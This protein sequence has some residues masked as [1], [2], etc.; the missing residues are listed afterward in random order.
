[1][2]N[3]SV[4]IGNENGYYPTVQSLDLKWIRFNLF[5]RVIL[6]VV[7]I[8]IMFISKAQPVI[9]SFTPTS[10]PIGTSV[11]ITGSNFNATIASNVVYFG[12][13]Q[14]TVTAASDTSLTVT[15]PAG[16]TYQPISVINTSTNLSGY[17]KQPFTV[18]FNG[19]VGQTITS[20]SF[21]TRVNYTTG[22]NP[23]SIVAI[24]DIDGDGKPDMVV[25]DRLT[26]TFS[27]LRNTSTVGITTSSFAAKV[28]FTTDSTPSSVAIG[29][30]DGDG[31]LD[32]V[33]TN[34]FKN[35]IWVYR[36]TS[37]SGSITT[38]SFATGV[39]FISDTL[40]L[41]TSVAIGDLDG[42]GKPDLAVTNSYSNTVSILKN[43]ST[44]GSITNASFAKSVDFTTGLGPISVA[45]ADIDGDGK[46]DLAV[47]N[48]NA[49]TISIFRNTTTTGTIST[50]SFAAKVDFTAG[51]GPHCVT[52]GD[53]NSD[54]KM[55]L[56]VANQGSNTI[57]VF[58]NTATSGTI[59]TSSLAAQV[60]IP[61]NGESPYYVSVGNIDGD[62]HPDI[63]VSNQIGNKMVV[64]RNNYAS[65]NI[66]ASS[67]AAGVTFATGN[68]PFSVAV[69]DLDGDGKPD[70]AVPN[71]GDNTVSVYW[72]ALSNVLPVSFLSFTGQYQNTP[73]DVLLQ[74]K[75]ANET[76]TS[77]FNIQRSVNGTLFTPLGRQDAAGNS[78]SVESYSY[79][80]NNLPT[81]GNTTLY[82]RLQEVDI[83][84][85]ITYSNI[86]P[87]DI[88]KKGTFKIYPN[89]AKS[90]INI[91]TDNTT[92]NGMVIISD[93]SGRVVLMY[94]LSSNQ[95]QQIPLGT[96]A[97]GL[98]GVSVITVDGKQTQQIVVQ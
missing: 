86:V 12:A 55:D 31:K 33:I 4:Y 41:P 43:T 38:S 68:Y 2:K 64:I 60:V 45:I 87:I 25:V 36:N 20:S 34:Q 75:T 90:Y 98:Y 28:D 76:N 74:W 65:G 1:M 48:F 89:P 17:S 97:K 83:D 71:F 93:A 51:T 27:I 73:G 42:D 5:M 58:T 84:G 14:A 10:G 40:S 3:N 15:V 62:T 95:V 82:Y 79:T 24:A 29:D 81:L 66:S 7:L 96:I 8:G 6:L 57:S 63:L 72:N 37:T 30:L 13:T 50:S 61:S 52:A 88:S 21:N 59:T 11:T 78:N 92:A 69:A 22:I 26:N 23:A 70:L 46:P 56:I 32:I 80:D 47:A 39:S 19:G 16:A 67:F 94:Q 9:S 91:E 18:T 44:A 54:G 77:S 85:S 35:K 49:K 53:L